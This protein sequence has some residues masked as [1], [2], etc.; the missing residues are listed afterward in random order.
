MKPVAVHILEDDPGVCDSLKIVLQQLGHRVS[1]YPD[2][3]TFFESTPPGRDDVVIVDL[4]LPGISGAHVIHWIN[5]LK[6]SPRVIA[7]SGQP[8]SSIDEALSDCDRAPILLRK[9]L[10]EDKLAAL[11]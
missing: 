6:A 7:I 11:L 5:A 3:E 10:T 8:Q 9:P 1:T 2:A 4:G